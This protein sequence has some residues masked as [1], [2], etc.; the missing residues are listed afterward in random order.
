MG[1]KL[2][3]TH[4]GMNDFIRMIKAEGV[5]LMLSKDGRLLRN[6]AFSNPTKETLDSIDL[7]QAALIDYLRHN[8]YLD[9]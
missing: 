4:M 8:S 7:N 9:A 5:Y 2:K 6:Y 3:V 1:E